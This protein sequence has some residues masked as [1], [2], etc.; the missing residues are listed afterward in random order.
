MAGGHN[1]EKW[2]D[3]SDDG[4][5]QQERGKAVAHKLGGGRWNHNQGTQEKC[6]E[7][8]KGNNDRCRY[9]N[10]KGVVQPTG[11]DATGLREFRVECR[12]GERTHLQEEKSA[13]N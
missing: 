13:D 6:S 11:A 4:G 3:E 7:H 1:A 12:E 10:R 9:E 2:G 5:D 8:S